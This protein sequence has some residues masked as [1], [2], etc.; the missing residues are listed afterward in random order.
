MRYHNITKEDMLN[1]D[2]LRVVL[3]VS[4]CTHACEGCQNPLPGIFA[5]VCLLMRRRTKNSWKHW[6]VIS[7][8]ASPFRAEILCTRKTFLTSPL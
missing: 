6:I 4:G 3:W 8:V 1:G 7:S 5:A 2:G